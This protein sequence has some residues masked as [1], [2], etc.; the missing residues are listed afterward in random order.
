VIQSAHGVQIAD[1]SYTFI[2]FFRSDEFQGTDC[3]YTIQEGE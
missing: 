1:P 3:K 2:T